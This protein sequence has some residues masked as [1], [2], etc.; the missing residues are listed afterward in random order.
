MRYDVIWHEGTVIQCLSALKP[1]ELNTCK[2][3]RPSFVVFSSVYYW[4]T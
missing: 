4:L 3:A 1:T 2:G